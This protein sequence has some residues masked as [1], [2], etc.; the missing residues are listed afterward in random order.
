M[1]MIVKS[2]AVEPKKTR[3]PFSQ[4]SRNNQKTTL[5]QHFIARMI[6][7]VT[8]KEYAMMGCAN[9][10]LD[11]KNKLIVQVCNHEKVNQTLLF[12]VFHFFC[13]RFLLPR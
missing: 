11:G 2:N 10:S 9:V 8:T 4:F 5:L 6:W 12:T 1:K 3:G 13:P 7:I